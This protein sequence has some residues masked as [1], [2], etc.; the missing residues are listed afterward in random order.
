MSSSVFGCFLNAFVCLPDSNPALA[1]VLGLLGTPNIDTV[2]DWRDPDGNILQLPSSADGLLYESA[3]DYCTTNWCIQSASD[4]LFSYESGTNFDYYQ[5]CV[6]PYPGSVNTEEAS[7]DLKDKCGNNTDCLTEGIIGGEE[8]AENALDVVEE[9]DKTRENSAD[10][11]PPSM[12]LDV[13]NDECQ[14]ALSLVPVDDDTSAVVVGSTTNAAPTGTSGQFNDSP[15]VYYQFEGSDRRVRIS[16]CTPET[17]FGTAIHVMAGLDNIACTDTGGFYQI[18]Y[19]SKEDLECDSTGNAATV[20]FFAYQDTTYRLAVSGRSATDSGAFGLSLSR[21]VLVQN[22]ECQNAKSVL[23]LDDDTTA[24]VVGSTTD[25]A[26]TGIAGQFNDSPVVYYQFDGSDRRVRIS[27][28]TPETNF[29]TAIHVMAGLDNIACTDT[30]GFYQ[31][32]Y[33]SEEDLECNSTG[34]AATVEFFAYQDTTYRF[35]VSGRSATDSGAFGLSL[36][37][38]VLVQ[39][40][41]CQTAKSVLPLDNDTTAVVVG[42]TT[43][44]APTGIAGQF[45]DSPVVYYQFD[46]SDRRVRISTCTPETNFDTAIHVMVGLDIIACTDTG[47][48]YQTDYSSEEDLECDSTGNAAT[49]EFLAEQDITYRLQCPVARLL[50]VVPLN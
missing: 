18:D 16:T 42:S 28:C 41:E 40:D 46:G 49:V 6:A 29:D 34:N 13:P 17:N 21:F 26:P 11:E 9:L 12:D 14:N 39:N 35:A 2:D 1:N 50:T 15:V 37:R 30:G 48:F 47:G 5:N 19:S 33:S 25:A 20:E 44:A 32:D 7:Q 36:S 38:F 3:Y 27:T 43:D 22:Y 10:R 45:N 4:S 8:D 24:V 31:I 23:P